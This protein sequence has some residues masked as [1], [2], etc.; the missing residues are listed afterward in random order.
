[1]EST[2]ESTTVAPEVRPD[3][4][5]DAGAPTPA[6]RGG[7]KPQQPKQAQ[8][9]QQKQS[10]KAVKAA[11]RDIVGPGE[12]SELY[13]R[14]NFLMQA[15]HLVSLPQSAPAPSGRVE[16]KDVKGK[17]KSRRK[18]APHEQLPGLTALGRHLARE[19]MATARKSSLKIDP[20]V[21]HSV[22]RRCST[23]MV[24]GA[25][26]DIDVT[27]PA[28]PKNAETAKTAES[29]PATA[30]EPAWKRMTGSTAPRVV[31]QCMA[32]GWTRTNLARPGYVPFHERAAVDPND[33]D[34]ER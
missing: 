13:R 16:K 5:S 1:M 21:K 33:L 29:E 20:S 6:G 11:R 7:K 10:K 30:A 19:M 18:H 3:A 31:Y 14:L 15:A 22:C 25:T 27:D 17:R 34:S 28:E 2:H 9:Q 4:A 8:K 24:P 12:G 26:C 32:C 23:F